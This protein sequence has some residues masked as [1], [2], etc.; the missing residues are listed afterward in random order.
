MAVSDLWSSLWGG[1]LSCLQSLPYSAW[2]L[3]QGA[4]HQ[5]FWS[6]N[7]Q[8]SSSIFSA[9]PW[10]G[11]RNSNCWQFC[12]HDPS[13]V[14]KKLACHKIFKICI[15]SKSILSKYETLDRQTNSKSKSLNLSFVNPFL[16]S[17]HGLFPCFVFLTL[18][19]SL[20]VFCGLSFAPLQKPRGQVG[21]LQIN[22]LKYN[23]GFL[24]LYNPRPHARELESLKTDF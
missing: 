15:A 4:T 10:N 6:K 9:P 7:V 1:S 2:P 3:F 12:I 18:L 8:S 14:I 17:T 24:K 11:Q 21:T 13:Q 22:N 23:P 5:Q 20:L 19:S 16:L